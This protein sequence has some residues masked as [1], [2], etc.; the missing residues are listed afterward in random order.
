MIISVISVIKPHIAIKTVLIFFIAKINKLY[1]KNIKSV[2]HTKKI[3]E[4]LLTKV[5]YSQIASDKNLNICKKIKNKVEMVSM[6]FLK[7]DKK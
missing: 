7:E 4:I 2:S 5:C 3:I 1:Y 6:L